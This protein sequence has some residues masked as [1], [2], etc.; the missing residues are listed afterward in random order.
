MVHK[1]PSEIMK[2]DMGDLETLE[3]DVELLNQTVASL[4]GEETD[5]EKLE[6]LKKWKN[7]LH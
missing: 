4:E 7:G 1:R 5:S 6:K 3:F 2:L